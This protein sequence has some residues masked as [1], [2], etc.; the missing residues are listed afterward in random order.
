MSVIVACPKCQMKLK[1]EES[2]FGKNIKCPGCGAVHGEG[3]AAAPPPPALPKTA[4]TFR[5]DED[6]D[7]SRKGRQARKAAA[8]EEDDDRPKKSAV[9]STRDDAEGH[10]DRP[11]RPATKKGRDDD[12]DDRPRKANGRKDG[13]D[14]AYD[15]K[16]RRGSK[17]APVAAAGMSNMVLVA[18][19]LGV[20]LGLG[21]V[22]LGLFAVLAA[23]I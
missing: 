14:D 9:K 3:A 2:A 11:A 1:V 22:I 8:E 13:D 6:Q 7:V 16:E 20:V 12:D 5:I 21:G 18:L 10:D 17:K 4:H 23:A 15:R 19:V